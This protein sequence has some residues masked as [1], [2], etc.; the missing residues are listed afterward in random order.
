[1]LNSVDVNTTRHIKYKQNKNTKNVY[2][3]Q[4]KFF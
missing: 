3:T 4:L 2:Y 1:M